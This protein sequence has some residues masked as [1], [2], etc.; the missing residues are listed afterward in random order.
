[1]GKKHKRAQLAATLPDITE[2]IGFADWAVPS[3][4]LSYSNFETLGASGPAYFNGIQVG[5][6]YNP[7]LAGEALYRTVDRMWRSSPQIAALINVQLLPLTQVKKW[8]QPASDAE[9]GVE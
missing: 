9:G 8:V 2:G 6:E 7:D 4:K 3:D 1:M 5:E